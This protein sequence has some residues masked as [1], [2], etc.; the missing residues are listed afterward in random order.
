MTRSLPRYGAAPWIALA[1]AL[2]L[3]VRDAVAGDGVILQELPGQE[4]LLRI[5][6]DGELFA[7]YVYRGASRPCLYPVLGPGGVPVTRRWPLQEGV[8]EDKDHPHHRSLWFSHGDVNGI[9][10]WSES[11]RAGKTVHAEF[12]E[13]SSGRKSGTL[14]TRN[15]LVAPDGT[16]VGTVLH[17]FHFYPHPVARLFDFNVTL[18]ASDG[19]LKLG[20]TKEGTM[21]VRLAETMRLKPNKFNQG[22]PTGHIVNSQGIRDDATWGKRAA[23]VDYYGPVEG[24]ILGV[25]IF[26]HPQNPRHPTWW[27][28]RDYGLFAANPFGIHDFEKKPA[29]TGNMVVPSGNQLTF[30]YRFLI[31]R[32]NEIEGQVAQF[33]QEYSKSPVPAP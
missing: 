32:G 10:F 29:G 26:D 9:D 1:L 4:G 20:D 33:Y 25:A 8:G 28:V 19:D 31:H 15:E 7:E 27:H 17:T 23:W 6:I 30:R 5:E 3:P 24:Q 21:A 11:A 14:R 18:V 16:R 2:S 13:I 22:K 12:L